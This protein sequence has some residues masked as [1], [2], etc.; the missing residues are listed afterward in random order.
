[1]YIP[2]SVV[3]QKYFGGL[4]TAERERVIKKVVKSMSKDRKFSV[5][6]SDYTQKGT[7]KVTAQKRLR[8]KRAE[9]RKS[10]SVP[11]IPKKKTKPKMPKGYIF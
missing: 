1:M 2:P 6:L 7:L 5:K 9:M 11:F 10:A 3:M 8:K 4:P